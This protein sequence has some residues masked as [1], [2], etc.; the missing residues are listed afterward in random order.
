MHQRAPLPPL[1]PSLPP[2]PH[3]S[4]WPALLLASKYS[5]SSEEMSEIAQLRTELLGQRKLGKK[6]EDIRGRTWHTT[7]ERT[8][9]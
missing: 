6:E 7:V 8:Q 5:S 2:C 4:E 3:L 9:D 1:G